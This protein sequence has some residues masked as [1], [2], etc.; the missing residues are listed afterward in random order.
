MVDVFGDNFVAMGLN[1]YLK[2]TAIQH[3]AEIESGVIAAASTAVVGGPTSAPTPIKVDPL[4][5]TF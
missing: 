4:L 2:L 3:K 5:F 1:P